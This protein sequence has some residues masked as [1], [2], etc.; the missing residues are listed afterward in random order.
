MGSPL[1][2]VQPEEVRADSLGLWVHFPSHR[3]TPQDR[4][5][6]RLIFTAVPLHYHT[7]FRGWLLDTGGSLPQPVHAGNAGEQ[8]NTSSLSVFGSLVETLSRFALSS[9]VVTPNG[10]GTN[11]VVAISYDL[12]HLVGQADVVVAIYDLAGRLVDVVSSARRPAGMHVEEWWGADGA[13]EA[14]PPGNYICRI[15]VKTQTGSVERSKLIAVA[16]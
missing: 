11:D 12:V 7:I 2:D 10:D 1:E 4:V 15:T 14:L 3:V 16:Y 8:I 6:I 13:A 5:P 9:R